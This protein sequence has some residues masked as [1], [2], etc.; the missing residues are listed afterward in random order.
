MQELCWKIVRSV[1]NKEFKGAIQVLRLDGL[2]EMRVHTGL[3]RTL[4][5][6]IT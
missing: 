6:L 5:I 3:Q 1:P 2:A 4:D